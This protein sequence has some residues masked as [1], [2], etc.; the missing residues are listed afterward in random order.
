MKNRELS[1][2]ELDQVTHEI[3]VWVRL[4]SKELKDK[5]KE[6]LQQELQAVRNRQLTLRTGRT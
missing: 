4:Q 1:E 5:I 6:N 3:G 2:K